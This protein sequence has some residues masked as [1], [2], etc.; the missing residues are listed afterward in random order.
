MES[1][2]L[3]AVKF[4]ILICFLLKNSTGVAQ[5]NVSSINEKVSKIFKVVEAVEVDPI[6]QVPNKIRGKLSVNANL[7]NENT[8]HEIVQ[9][10]GDIYHFDL[11]KP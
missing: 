7:G 3:M 8:V 10:I 5:T 2:L 1:K 4:F 6:R 11:S 9:Q